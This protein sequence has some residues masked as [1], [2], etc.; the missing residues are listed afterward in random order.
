MTL[1]RAKAAQ[2][3]VR[4]FSERIGHS[5]A[6]QSSFTITIIIIIGETGSGSTTQI[7]QVAISQH[8]PCVPVLML[9]V[10]LF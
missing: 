4:D 10:N 8:A 1:A 6:G 5:C 3:T 2:L 7:S 9:C